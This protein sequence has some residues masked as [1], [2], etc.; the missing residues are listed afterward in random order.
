MSA[1]KIKARTKWKDIYPLFS[2]DTRYLNI[3][4]NP[5]SNP[6]ELFWDLVD[7]M[8]QKLDAK[9][10]VVET[11]I[12]QFSDKFPKTADDEAQNDTDAN[13][14]QNE[15]ASKGLK[16]SPETTKEELLNMVKD[17]EDVKALSEED[18]DEIYSTVRTESQSVSVCAEVTVYADA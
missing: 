12:K 6:L 15:E 9:V 17:D 5:G 7:G 16:F 8:D 3:L 18:F 1:G 11:A 4:G 2:K 10:A 13:A 14:E